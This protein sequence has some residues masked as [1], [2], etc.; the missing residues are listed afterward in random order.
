MLGGRPA[1]LS[2]DGRLRVLVS[3]PDGNPEDCA[4]MLRARIGGRRGQMLDRARYRLRPG[5]RANVAFD[6][7]PRE[8]RRAGDA[9]LTLQADEIDADGRERHIFR[10]M[11]V[12]RTLD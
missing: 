5:R 4:G 7:S 3:C 12:R 1:L 10:R 2:A 11:S 8:T 6:L 9:K